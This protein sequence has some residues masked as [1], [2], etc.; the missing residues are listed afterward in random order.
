MAIITIRYYG[1]AQ[2]I[3]GANVEKTEWTGSL[4]DLLD[5]LYKQYPALNNTKI[6]VSY[7]LKILSQEEIVSAA[8]NAILSD[9]DEVV[10]LPPF[11]G[12]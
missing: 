7:N 9:G 11:A 8:A 12:G 2:D 3:T 1:I 5:N 6:R 10:F 4:K